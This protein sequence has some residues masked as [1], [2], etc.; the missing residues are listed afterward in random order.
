MF[1]MRSRC[2]F[3]ELSLGCVEPQRTVNSFLIWPGR[4]YHP[5][6]ERELEGARRVSDDKSEWRRVEPASDMPGSGI[7][8]KS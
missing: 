6:N 8:F 1:T 2:S 7:F 4:V 3:S 5:A